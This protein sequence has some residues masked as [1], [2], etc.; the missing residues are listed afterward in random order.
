MT[1][2]KPTIFGDEKVNAGNGLEIEKNP[3]DRHLWHVA[4]PAGHRLLADEVV[5]VRHN[6][7][8]IT[9]NDAPAEFRSIS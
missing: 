8:Q 1:S 4:G 9:W 2:G 6:R 3:K 5:L 7:L